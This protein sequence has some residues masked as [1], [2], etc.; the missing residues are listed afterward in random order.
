M[1]RSMTA[2]SVRLLRFVGDEL[3]IERIDEV[4]ADDLVRA[5]V[6][7][8]APLLVRRVVPLAI[9]RLRV[10]LDVD[11]RA[12]RKARLAG[13]RLRGARWPA[14]HGARSRAHRR[15]RSRGSGNTPRPRTSPSTGHRCRSTPS[16][17]WTDRPAREGAS[18]P[19]G[20]TGCAAPEYARRR[21]VT[22]RRASSTRP[23]FART[24]S[25]FRS[26]SHPS[27]L[28]KPMPVT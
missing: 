3:E 6:A 16:G 28:S 23:R 15:R 27:L 19:S 11:E 5:R 12:C 22:C 1:M 24:L 10:A 20:P 8:P 4:V 9:A 25:A 17:S 7:L 2:R 21:R 13:D 14:C 18:W 26:R